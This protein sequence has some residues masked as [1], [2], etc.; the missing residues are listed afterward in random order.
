MVAFAKEATR[1][2]CRIG[3]S[4]ERNGI[5]IDGSSEKKLSFSDVFR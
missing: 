5:L 1:I 3:K 2:K 4:K